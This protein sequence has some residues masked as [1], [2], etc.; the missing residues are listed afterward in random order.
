MRDDQTDTPQSPQNQP[1]DVR[2]DLQQHDIAKQGQPRDASDA[3][4]QQDMSFGAVEDPTTGESD[5]ALV[6]PPMEGPSSVTRGDE[7]DAADVD[8]HEEIMGG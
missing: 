8:P 3:G 4:S 6:T 5:Q 2:S 1:A 7:D